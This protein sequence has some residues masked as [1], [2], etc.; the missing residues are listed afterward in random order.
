MI[1][2]LFFD[3]LKYFLN[4]FNVAYVICVSFFYVLLIIEWLFNNEPPGKS[5]LGFYVVKNNPFGLIQK[6]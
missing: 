2:W 1:E 5:K 3:R 6:G 4:D